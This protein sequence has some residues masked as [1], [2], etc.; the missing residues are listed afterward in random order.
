MKNPDKELTHFA[1]TFSKH[2]KKLP[3]GFYSSANGTY[4]LEYKKYIKGSKTGARIVIDGARSGLVEIDKREY[5]SALVTADWVF[6]II[7]WCHVVRA[8][9]GDCL[10]ADS[11][12]LDW[13]ATTGRSMRNIFIGYCYLLQN[14]HSVDNM[15]R[16]LP[17]YKKTKDGAK[18]DS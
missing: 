8:V 11:I 6:Y 2:Y 12:M 3:A 18:R 5:K 17:I 1:D 10:L 4:R 15:K 9:K 16:F 13:Y 14:T 7:I